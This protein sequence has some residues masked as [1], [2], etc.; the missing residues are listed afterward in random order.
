VLKL[1]DGVNI[2]HAVFGRGEIATS[3]LLTVFTVSVE[4]VCGAE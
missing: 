3:A 4:A 2:V 1:E